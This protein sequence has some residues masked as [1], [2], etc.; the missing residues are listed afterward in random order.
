MKRVQFY[1]MLLTDFPKEF[2]GI[3]LG[4][5]PARTGDHV[6]LDLKQ[7][8][9]VEMTKS[10]VMRAA[11]HRTN[12]GDWGD[13]SVFEPALEQLLRSLETEAELNTIGRFTNWQSIVRRLSQRLRLQRVGFKQIPTAI[14]D[15]PAFVI[16]GP[17][18]TGSTL[19]QRLLALDPENNFLRSSDVLMPMPATR[20]GSEGDKIKS[21]QVALGI[22]T[23]YEQI[24]GLRV[25]HES[26]AHL[27]EEE[28]FLLDFSFM[29]L[30][31]PLRAHVP[32]FWSWVFQSG[33][34]TGLYRELKHFISYAGQY[35]KGSR[36]VLKAPHHL[37]MLQQLMEGFPN[38]RIIWIH[39]DPVRF[40]T[41]CASL[42]RTI[43]REFSDTVTDE[44]VGREWLDLLADGI[45]RAMKYRNAVG[46]SRIVD[47]YTQDLL[48]DPQK[49]VASIYDSFG[50]PLPKCMFE[51]I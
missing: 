43:R 14:A 33:D 45:S 27:P 48:K 8:P 1:A 17:P 46:E 23:T 13:K 47:V 19:L 25:L 41:S 10:A 32:G 44:K 24:P 26:M 15:R 3:E 20:L 51:G 37:W 21:R 35:R 42:S 12:C 7:V 38:A 22:E 18:R 36:W 31:A 30:L 11:E 5:N 16:T 50:I 29:C 49:T 39:R 9:E 28:V 40:V 4:S 34:L 6:M 2:T